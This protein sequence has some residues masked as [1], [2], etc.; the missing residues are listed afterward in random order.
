[1]SEIDD[2]ITQISKLLP[3][4]MQEKTTL[5]EGVRKDV[6]DAMDDSD[7]TNPSVAF[8]SPFEVAK[9]LS[10]AQDWGTEPASWTRRFFATIID[11][12]ITGTLSVIL[13]LPGAI[14]ILSLFIPPEDVLE[15]VFSDPFTVGI[16]FQIS[17]STSSNNGAPQISG[18]EAFMFL[19]LLALLISIT[20]LIYIGYYL[21]KKEK[22]T[23]I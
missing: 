6:K 8:G 14:F 5:L 15:W 7:E 4:P 19:I 18:A 22:A 9:N 21:I 23:I 1:M 11:M 12:I 10:E 13:F 17:F 16:G 3:Y 2:Y 20:N